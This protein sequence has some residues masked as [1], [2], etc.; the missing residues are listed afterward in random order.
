MDL[1]KRDLAIQEQ[2][3]SCHSEDP[4][5]VLYAEGIYGVPRHLWQWSGITRFTISSDNVAVLIE[6]GTE[7]PNSSLGKFR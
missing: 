7:S 2:T 5:V 1:F 4:Y 6:W 3:R